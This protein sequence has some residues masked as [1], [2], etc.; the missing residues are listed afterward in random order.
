MLRLLMDD[1]RFLL[2]EPVED[3][4]IEAGFSIGMTDT[5]KA[6][7]HFGFLCFVGTVILTIEVLDVIEN[8]EDAKLFNNSFEF[9]LKR[10]NDSIQIP[11]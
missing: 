7:S 3:G 11:K 1:P 4:L 6:V 9:T 2:T 5:Q 10:Y 8:P